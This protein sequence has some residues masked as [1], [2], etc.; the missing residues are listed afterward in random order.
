MVIMTSNFVVCYIFFALSSM[1]SDW[2]PSR[3][4]SV[5]AGR[6]ISFHGCMGV[7][8]QY[9]TCQPNCQCPNEMHKYLENHDCY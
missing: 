7:K 1:S 5:E 8:C 3:H 6:S 4:T 9:G 2:Q